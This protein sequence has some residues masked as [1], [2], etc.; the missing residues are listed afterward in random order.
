MST[1]RP[2]PA[3]LIALAACETREPP[4]DPADASSLIADLN[5][6]HG[7]FIA[8]LKKRHWSDAGAFETCVL[9]PET[10]VYRDDR[11]EKE[12]GRSETF[13]AMLPGVRHD[14]YDSYWQENERAR[15]IAPLDRG[16]MKLHVLT[17][18]EDEKLEAIAEGARFR[19]YWDTFRARYGNAVR[20]HISAAG[21]SEDR[22]QALIYYAASFDFLAAWGSY[23]LLKREGDRWE[24]AEEHCVWVS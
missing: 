10:T 17:K 8:A 16:A 6:L 1:I 18:A 23:C 19:E 22:R 13:K 11:E 2:I 21:F 14:T 12:P 24:I 20:V 4:G 5:A 9:G 15:P 3:L 7:D